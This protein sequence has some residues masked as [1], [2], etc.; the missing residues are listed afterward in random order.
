MTDDEIMAEEKRRAEENP[1]EE[2]RNDEEMREYFA[3]SVHVTLNQEQSAQMRYLQD[4]IEPRPPL[5]GMV[6]AAVA[7]W[8]ADQS[9]EL[10]IPGA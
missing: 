9:E 5:T 8:V 4:Q 3:R 7:A 6:R 10:G 1:E 2:R